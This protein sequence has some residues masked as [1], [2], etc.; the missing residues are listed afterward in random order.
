MELSG[1][2]GKAVERTDDPSPAGNCGPMPGKDG[3]E[4]RAI[5]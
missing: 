1:Q 4:R 5:R 3:H 2:T